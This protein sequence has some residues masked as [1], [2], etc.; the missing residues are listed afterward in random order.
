MAILPEVAVILFLFF[1]DSFDCGNGVYIQN[2]LKCDGVPDCANQSDE[3]P[4]AAGCEGSY[5]ECNIT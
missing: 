1:I 3:D 4:T 5:T 2:E